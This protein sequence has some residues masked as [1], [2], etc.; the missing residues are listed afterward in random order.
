[1]VSS[2]QF[3]YRLSRPKFRP[4][5][6]AGAVGHESLV[7]RAVPPLSMR[8]KR[9]DRNLGREARQ[10]RARYVWR[11]GGRPRGRAAGIIRC[12]GERLPR[13]Q[14]CSTVPHIRPWR[15]W[16]VADR[17]HIDATV[18]NHLLIVDFVL[19]LRI[20][21]ANRSRKPGWDRWRIVPLL[22]IQPPHRDR[23]PM[24]H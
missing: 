3:G 4:P 8:P 5:A 22:P 12:S 18:T 16:R 20:L 23:C 10:P 19:R 2:A 21:I 15:L 13:V 24:R 14:D 7:L 9:G 6:S 17:T 11:R 1:M